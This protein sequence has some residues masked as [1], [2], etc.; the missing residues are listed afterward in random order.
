LGLD[1]LVYVLLLNVMVFMRF[2]YPVLR[3]TSGS[4]IAREIRGAPRP[5]AGSSGHLSL[6]PRAFVVRHRSVT[7]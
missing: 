4:G 3:L 7:R 2:E 6:F 1:S 5:P